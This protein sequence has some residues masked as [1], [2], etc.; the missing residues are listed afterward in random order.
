MDP[1]TGKVEMVY[2]ASNPEQRRFVE[3]FNNFLQ[4]SAIHFA[5]EFTKGVKEPKESFF[6][7]DQK[8]GIKLVRDPPGSLASLQKIFIRVF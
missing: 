2:T 5:Q 8:D 4:R 6:F 1:A 7:D 3:L